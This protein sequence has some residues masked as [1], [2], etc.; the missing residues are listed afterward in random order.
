MKINQKVEIGTDPWTGQQGKIVHIV[1]KQ[2]R[3]E[4]I[5]QFRDDWCWF[6]YRELKKI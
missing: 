3:K 5:V 6:N 4:Y 1:K 2:G